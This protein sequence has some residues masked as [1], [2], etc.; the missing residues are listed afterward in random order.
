MPTKYTF[1]HTV[2]LERRDHDYIWQVVVERG[3]GAEGFDRALSQILREHEQSSNA[4][5]NPKNRDL[6]QVHPPFP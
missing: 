3:L 6:K 1:C 2:E 4:E 5:S